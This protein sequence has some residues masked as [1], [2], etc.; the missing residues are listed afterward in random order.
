MSDATRDE[1]R[2]RLAAAYASASLADEA[3]RVANNARG[4]AMAAW[5]EADEAR[6][7]TEAAHRDA[8][9][10]RDI[11]YKALLACESD[12]RAIAGGQQP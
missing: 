5:R 11:A 7:I 6:Y 4:D 3:V 8:R 1:I 9:S 2:A 12:W 10:K